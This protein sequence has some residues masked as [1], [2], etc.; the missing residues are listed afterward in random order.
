MHYRLMK[1]TDISDNQEK[2]KIYLRCYS[3]LINKSFLI[4]T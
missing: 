3:C 4:P 2:H 1:P